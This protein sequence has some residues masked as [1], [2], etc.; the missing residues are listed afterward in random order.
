VRLPRCEEDADGDLH[1][2]RADGECERQLTDTAR[3]E[4][5]AEWHGGLACG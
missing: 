5:P 1:P 2:I 4:T 3:W